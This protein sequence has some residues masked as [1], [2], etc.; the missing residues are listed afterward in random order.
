MGPRHHFLHHHG[1]L[2]NIPLGLLSLLL[3]FTPFSLM[4]TSLGLLSFKLHFLGNW[5]KAVGDKCCRKR[6]FKEGKGGE[7]GVLMKACSCQQ[8]C[9]YR[10]C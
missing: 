8:Y 9:Q 5:A 1:H 6:T 2:D 3:S 10:P 4:S 7:S